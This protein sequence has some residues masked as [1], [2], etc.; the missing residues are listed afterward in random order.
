MYVC[1]SKY[2]NIWAISSVPSKT[3]ENTSVGVWLKLFNSVSNDF[4][5]ASATKDLLGTIGVLKVK[6][7]VNDGQNS[8][9]AYI[10]VYDTS[11]SFVTGGGWINFLCGKM[12]F[13]RN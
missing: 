12:A 6:A 4:G 9:T 2:A 1:A 5:F 3:L 8:S 11:G 7:T 10:Q 13:G